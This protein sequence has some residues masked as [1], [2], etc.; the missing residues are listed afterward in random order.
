MRQF[1]SGNFFLREVLGEAVAMNDVRN[2]R[3]AELAPLAKFCCFKRFLGSRLLD[4]TLEAFSY[5][6][7]IRGEIVYDL[8]VDD[9]QATQ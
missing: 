6:S 1:L 7:L 5:L 8:Q 4:N 3:K 9:L 2:H